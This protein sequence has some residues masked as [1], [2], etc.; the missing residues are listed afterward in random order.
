MEGIRSLKGVGDYTAAAIGSIA[1]GLPVAVVDGNVYRLLSRYYGI[2]TPIN[3]TE[4]KKEF[5]A[6]AQSLLP[7]HQASAFN[8]AMMDFGAV[9]CTPANPRCGDCPLM[10]S[11]AAFRSGE[12]ERLP[13]KLRKLKVSERRLTY[14]YI[15]HQGMTAIHRRPSGD[16]WQGLYEPWVIEDGQLSAAEGTV[17]CV[18]PPP[19]HR[20]QLLARQVKHVLTHRIIYADFYLWEADERPLL[21]ADYFWISETDIDRYAVP[22]LIEILFEKLPHD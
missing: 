9:Q 18:P 8:Q 7:V 21:P 10:E 5:A 15:R 14:I 2:S 6:L 22:R 20:C 19:L 4:G 3:S 1:F 17:P 13:V 12:V 16:I 11:C